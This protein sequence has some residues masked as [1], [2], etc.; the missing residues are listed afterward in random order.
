[1]TAPSQN[2]VK[3]GFTRY[4][5]TDPI[6]PLQRQKFYRLQIIQSGATASSGNSHPRFGNGKRTTS[7]PITHRFCLGI[8]H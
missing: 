6:D 2:G 1:M 5:V 3:N 4:T 7:V 8:C